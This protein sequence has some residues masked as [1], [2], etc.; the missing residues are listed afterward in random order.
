MMKG[1]MGR[2]LNWE[3]ALECV[4]A[5]VDLTEGELDQFKAWKVKMD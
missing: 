2:C 5:R 1:I 3:M 4:R